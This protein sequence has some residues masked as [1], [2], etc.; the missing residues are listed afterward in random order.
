MTNRWKLTCVAFGCWFVF[1]TAFSIVHELGH[2]Y[3]CFT[4]GHEYILH[5]GGLQGNYTTCLGEN[6]ELGSYRMAGGFFGASIPLALYAILK[7]KLTGLKKG[8]AIALVTVG[9]VQFYNMVVETYF[10]DFYMTSGINTGINSLMALLLLFFL[11]QRNS[12]KEVKF[13]KPKIDDESK[14]S[15]DIPE[16]IFKRSIVDIVRGRKP[17]KQNQIH[18][19]KAEGRATLDLL[20]EDE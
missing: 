1:L 15:A 10:F 3:A 6:I 8:I 18:Q 16:N 2:A 4:Q 17:L 20:K 11:I 12:Q 13:K 7:S 9:I 14:Y 5:L 19:V